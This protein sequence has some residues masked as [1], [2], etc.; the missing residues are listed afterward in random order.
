MDSLNETSYRDV[1][2]IKLI[3]FPRLLHCAKKIKIKYKNQEICIFAYETSRQRDNTI[4][5]K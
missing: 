5:Q 2:D 1:N 3:S 4:Y